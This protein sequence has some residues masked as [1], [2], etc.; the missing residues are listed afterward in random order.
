V[1]SVPGDPP[2]P[3]QRLHVVLDPD[4]PTKSVAI[5]PQPGVH[6][7]PDPSLDPPDNEDDDVGTGPDQ[8]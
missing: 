4:D 6:A 8:G 1:A 7:G 3:D 2:D 5:V